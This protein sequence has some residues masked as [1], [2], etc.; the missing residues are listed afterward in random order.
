MSLPRA[1]LR[2]N[3][4]P[5]LALLR[6]GRGMI[7]R[8]LSPTI[9]AKK[10]YSVSFSIDD[11]NYTVKLTDSNLSTLA[12]KLNASLNLANPL[13]LFHFEEL[14]KIQN[15][16]NQLGVEPEL[17]TFVSTDLEERVKFLQAVGSTNMESNSDRD[18]NWVEK[19]PAEQRAGIQVFKESLVS[20]LPVTPIE[21][22][23]D[24][25]VIAS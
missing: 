20:P 8:V 1:D 22:D 3:S 16:L 5:D 2:L 25:T 4:K 19:L 18:P 24:E 13:E 12:I 14:A 7:Y 10:Y 21:S 17:K 15:L 11:I 23:D 6:M 9:M